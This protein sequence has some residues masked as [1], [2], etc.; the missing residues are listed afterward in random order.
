MR[1]VDSAVLEPS[2]PDSPRFGKVSA[3]ERALRI[4][5]E[6]SSSPACAITQVRGARL[7]ESEGPIESSRDPLPKTHELR[8]TLSSGLKLPFVEGESLCGSVRSFSVG[9]MLVTF[10]ALIA[11]PSGEVLMAHAFGTPRDASPLP[12]WIFTPGP[13]RTA[14]APGRDV[15]DSSEMVVAHGKVSVRTD[16]SVE[17]TRL[18]APDGEFMVHAEGYTTTGDRSALS[19]SLGRSGYGFTIVRIRGE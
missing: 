4:V 16:H 17:Y 9:M 13:K 14:K 10:E 18:G 2:T 6:D 19:G 3:P 7:D 5:L 15:V 8:I 1:S 11:R 12:G